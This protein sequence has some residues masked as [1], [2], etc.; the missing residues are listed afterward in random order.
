MSDD[1]A[2]DLILEGRMTVQTSDTAEA[3]HLKITIPER[4]RVELVFTRL[5]QASKGPFAFADYTKKPDARP[6]SN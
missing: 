1:F 2:T 5:Q 4:R 6:A 3:A